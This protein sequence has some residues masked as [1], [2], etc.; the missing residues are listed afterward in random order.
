[1]TEHLVP[2]SSANATSPENR[3]IIAA[4]SFSGPLPPPQILEEYDRI[5]PG[6]AT[7]IIAMAEK[8]ADHRRRLETQ[9]VSSDIANSRVGLFCG[10]AIGI[11]GLAAGTI[12]AIKGNPQAGVGMGFLTLGSLVSVFVYGS[13]LRVKERHTNPND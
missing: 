8:Q 10:L 6:S 2:P 3:R 1:M 13:R 7:R 9:I 12:I 4:T 5:A 11:G